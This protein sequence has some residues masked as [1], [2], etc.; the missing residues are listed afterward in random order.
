VHGMVARL[1]RTRLPA[2]H[3]PDYFGGLYL[4]LPQSQLTLHFWGQRT[5]EKSS[6]ASCTHRLPADHKAS[7]TF[8]DVHLDTQVNPLPNK[9]CERGRR[10]SA[11]EGWL[12]DRRV[13]QLQCNMA[14]QAGTKPYHPTH[15]LL[16]TTPSSLTRC[17]RGI[18]LIGQP[19]SPV[20][21]TETHM[22]PRDCPQIAGRRLPSP[23]TAL[24]I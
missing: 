9:A 18:Y 20:D 11:A 21:R 14:G 19:R 2:T 16:P 1:G 13:G 7:T 6:V 4:D 10:E 23:A 15:T 5:A 12:D 17:V 3:E 22:S 8:E 24:E